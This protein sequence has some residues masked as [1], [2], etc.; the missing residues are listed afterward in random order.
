MDAN[1]ILWLPVVGTTQLRYIG[2][3]AQVLVEVY[4]RCGILSESEFTE[5]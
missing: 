1:L 4:S 2:V 3:N 5:L